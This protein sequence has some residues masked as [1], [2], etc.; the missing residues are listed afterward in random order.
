MWSKLMLTLAFFA[1][2]GA[3]A[4]AIDCQKDDSKGKE[5]MEFTGKLVHPVF[6]IGG[7]TTGTVIETKKGTYELD[8]G[9]K[10]E[11]LKQ[12]E[13]L[14]GKQVVVVGVLRVVKGIEIPER[15]IISVAEI[16]EIKKEKGVDQ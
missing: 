7:E 10:K 8:L 5:K 2:T 13:L 3:L 1:A 11:I 14:K 6:A 12:V 16:R 9:G 4:T 15:Q